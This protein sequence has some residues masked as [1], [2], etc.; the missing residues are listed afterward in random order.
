[1]TDALAVYCGACAAG[2]NTPCCDPLTGE[3]CDPHDIRI[4]I[5]KG[6]SD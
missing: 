1:M 5:A 4:R 3:E 2:P 6:R